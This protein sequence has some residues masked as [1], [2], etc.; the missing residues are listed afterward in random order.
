MGNKSQ[1]DLQRLLD[2]MIIIGF[3]GNLHS[4]LEI[5]NRFAY[6]A[7][8]FVI[9]VA[10]VHISVNAFLSIKRVIGG[11]SEAGCLTL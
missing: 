9:L 1:K 3:F 6:Y 2:R 10:L 11:W 5:C 7:T 4:C 8:I